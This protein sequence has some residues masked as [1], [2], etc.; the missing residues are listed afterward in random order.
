M[1]NSRMSIP[2]GTEPAGDRIAQRASS[3]SGTGR[4]HKLT[5]HLRDRQRWCHACAGEL[6]TTSPGRIMGLWATVPLKCARCGVL[7][8]VGRMIGPGDKT[9]RAVTVQPKPVEVSPEHFG[10]AEEVLP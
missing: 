10:Y 2:L 6:E 1:A 7:C 3:W 4:G 9:P 5:E 8:N